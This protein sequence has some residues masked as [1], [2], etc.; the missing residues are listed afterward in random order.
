M[1]RLMIQIKK[2]KKIFLS[3]LVYPEEV[4]KRKVKQLTAYPHGVLD[5][6]RVTC[7]AFPVQVYPKI[8][9]WTPKFNDV[10]YFDDAVQQVLDAE[11]AWEVME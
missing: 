4:A 8:A 9:V 6:D 11:T 10:R 3:P 1:M 7:I 2:T 5:S